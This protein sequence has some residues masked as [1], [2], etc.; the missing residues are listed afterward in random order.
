MC[1]LQ[2]HLVSVKWTLNLMLFMY[3][4]ICLEYGMALLDCIVLESLRVLN[5]LIACLIYKVGLH[6]CQVI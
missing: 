6:Y 2:Y 1:I 5:L 4:P 3:F